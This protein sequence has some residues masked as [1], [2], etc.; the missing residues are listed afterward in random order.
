[1]ITAVKM[2]RGVRIHG[3]RD[4]EA[5]VVRAVCGLLVKD[6]VRLP[7]GAEATCGRC[8]PVM[9]AE[10]AREAKTH[11]E[12]GLLVRRFGTKAVLFAGDEDTAVM[13]G[14]VCLEVGVPPEVVAAR[15]VARG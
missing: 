1:M 15:L 13:A 10:A 11:R 8:G 6:A 7:P 3:T 14:R 4:P 5:E 2:N 12:A 9:R